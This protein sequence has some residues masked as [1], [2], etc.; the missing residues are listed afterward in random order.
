MSVAWR[1][2][3]NTGDP[4]IDADHMHLVDL[5][6]NFETALAG[7]TIDHKRI[8]RVLLGLV[9]YTGDHF[10]REEEI[11]L[12]VRYPYC[13]S[14]RRSHRDVLK[15][16]SHIVAEYVKC[17][18]SPERDAM[19]RNLGGFLREWLVDPISLR[20][21]SRRR[22]RTSGGGK[23]SWHRKKWP[24]SDF[25]APLTS[26]RGAGTEAEGKPASVRRYRRSGPGH[27][28]S[29]AA[30]TP[31]RWACAGIPRLPAHGPGRPGFPW[32]CC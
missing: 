6:N 24:R 22:T 23:R 20:C 27:W 10:K 11:Q 18:D 14:H 25:P 8:A 26:P 32:C 15:K 12:A 13:D 9:E 5:I 30:T 29:A 28:R 2:A 4:T 31:W 16:L 7:K 19:V 21:R 3:M 17:P 1:D